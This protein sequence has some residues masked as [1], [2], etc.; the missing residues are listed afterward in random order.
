MLHSP[1]SAGDHGGLLT[2][3]RAQPH[4]LE[5]AQGAAMLVPYSRS[6]GA[7]GLLQPVRCKIRS[8]VSRGSRSQWSVCDGVGTLHLSSKISLEVKAEHS[9]DLR[10]GRLHQRLP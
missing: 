3:P 8:S 2:L 7:A 4:Y 5:D 10:K 1:S 9:L 6:M